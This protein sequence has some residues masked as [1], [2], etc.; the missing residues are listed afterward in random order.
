MLIPVEKINEA[1]ALYKDE[2]IQEIIAYFGTE[3]TYNEKTRSCSCPWHIDKTPSFIWNDKDNC[4]HCFS[5]SRNYGI[6]DLYMDKGMTYIEAVQELF[7]NV[8]ME[9]DCSKKYINN[10]HP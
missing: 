9:Y 4:F 10:N 1:K 7:K 5:C 8:G 6:L 3:N 2:A